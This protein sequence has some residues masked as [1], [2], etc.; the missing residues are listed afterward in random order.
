MVDKNALIIGQKLFWMLLNINHLIFISIYEVGTIIP[1]LQ[2]YRVRKGK[3]QLN[4]GSSLAS[5]PMHL[6]TS[7]Y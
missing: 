3:P 1:I 2:T 4:P 5:D 6:T 7:L